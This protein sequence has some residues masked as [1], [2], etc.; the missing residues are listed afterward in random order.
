MDF[1]TAVNT[2]TKEECF[3][4]VTEV[5][6]SLDTALQSINQYVARRKLQRRLIDDSSHIDYN[7][8]NQRKI[9]CNELQKSDAILDI[10]NSLNQYWSQFGFMDKGSSSDF[11]E[12]LVDVFNAH[13]VSSFYSDGE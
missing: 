5:T 13:T 9:Q 6:V 11:C 2:Q 4:E 7:E 12:M 8:I 1:K 10:Y 3:P